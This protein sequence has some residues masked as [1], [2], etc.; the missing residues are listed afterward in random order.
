MDRADRQLVRSR[1][2]GRCEYCGIHEDDDFVFLFH[3]DHIVPRKHGGTDNDA[4]L[5]LACH[6]CNLH[7]GANIA[8]IDPET[9][10]LL[11]LFNPRKDEWTRHFMQQKG[12]ILGLTAVGRTTIQVLAMNRDD[13]IHLRRSLEEQ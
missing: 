1:A 4:N 9:G 8:G 2:L 13:R 3:V 6:H 7:K 10:L 11:P 12:E 5:A